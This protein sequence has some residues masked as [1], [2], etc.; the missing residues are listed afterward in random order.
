MRFHSWP[1]NANRKLSSKLT[2]MTVSTKAWHTWI[3]TGLHRRIGKTKIFGSRVQDNIVRQSWSCLAS[4]LFTN[5]IIHTTNVHACC[6][7]S[8]IVFG[9]SSSSVYQCVAELGALRILPTRCRWNRTIQ[10]TNHQQTW[11]HS[12][13]KSTPSFHS[14][15][16]KSCALTKVEA[17]MVGARILRRR[18]TV[19]SSSQSYTGPA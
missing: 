12:R 19:L 18:I 15:V 2:M 4:E 16:R 11:S 10:V 8:S 3:A 14:G 5:Y 6:A 7:A 1:S 13:I 17:L 9:T